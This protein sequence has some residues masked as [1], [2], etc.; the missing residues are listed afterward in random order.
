MANKWDRSCNN[1]FRPLDDT[2]VRC[3]CGYEYPVMHV[4]ITAVHPKATGLG[5]KEAR[6]F[7]KQWVGKSGDFILEE[8]YKSVKDTA[9][10]AGWYGGIFI[11]DDSP[12]ESELQNAIQYRETPRSQ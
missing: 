6:E 3:V 2:A 10:E 1:C 9:I 4:E 8:D 12:T 11:P 5:R 7:R